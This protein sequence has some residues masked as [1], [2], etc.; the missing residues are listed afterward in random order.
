[1]KKNKILYGSIL[2]SVREGLNENEQ[3][4]LLKSN[5]I[6]S[7]RAYINVLWDETIRN[8]Q[9]TNSPIDSPELEALGEIRHFMAVLNAHIVDIQNNKENKH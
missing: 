4:N 3:L 6:N 5:A 8:H 9:P 1:M 2:E 7:F